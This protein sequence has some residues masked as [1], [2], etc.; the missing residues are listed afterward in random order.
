LPDGTRRTHTDPLKGRVKTWA[1]DLE[2]EIRNG[3]WT[4]PR[5]GRMTVDQWWAKW[6]D[7]RV[8]E[9]ATRDRDAS[10]YRNHVKPR[11]GAVPLS[12]VTS[13]DVEA[14]I[15]NM[16]KLG[17]GKPTIQHAVRLLRHLMGEAAKHRLIKANPVVDA[18]LPKAAKHVDRFL[19]RDE[20]DRL[21]AEVTH[22]RDR[23]MISLLCLA[24]LRW[25]EV[26]GLH[27]HRVNLATRRLLV[28]EAAR[29]DRTIKD[30]P[31]SSAG[32]RYV[33]IVDELARALDPVL[34]P[35]STELVFPGVSY[36][37]WRRR[38]FVPAVERA[39]LALPWPTIHDLRHTFGSWLAEGG[40]PPTDIMALMGHGSLR[41]TERYMHAYES[42]FERAVSALT[43]P[44]ALPAAPVDVVD[45]EIVEEN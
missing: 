24:G 33:P 28:V 18:K 5:S 9:R 12:A 26:A 37:N 3:T 22:P 34:V 29:R 31:K 43:R 6:S 7:T 27:H 8:I 2:A 4:D 20:W 40:T 38:V 10:H 13:W 15:A 42:R 21:A 39:E 36:T 1:E 23:A 19:T 17:V 16:V 30:M 45:A 41:A 25:G 44:V 11:W 35:G 14:W 32:Q